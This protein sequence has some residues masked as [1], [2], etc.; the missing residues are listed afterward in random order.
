M[1][2]LKLNFFVICF[3]LPSYCGPVRAFCKATKYFNFS[4][5]S[6]LQ[7]KEKLSFVTATVN[8]VLMQQ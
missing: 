5:F 2:F 4:F 1:R 3:D 7:P 6:L 8:A